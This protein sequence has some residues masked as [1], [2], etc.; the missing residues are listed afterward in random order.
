MH[1]RVRVPARSNAKVVENCQRRVEVV[2]D[3]AL[4]LR[5]QPKGLPLL[6]RSWIVL[7]IDEGYK[8][9]FERYVCQVREDRQGHL[10]KKKWEGEAARIS[11]IQFSTL[12]RAVV[13]A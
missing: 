12:K 7:F 11:C 4:R 3:K 2:V 6:R 5:G 8:R 13:G 9:N 10:Q 1:T